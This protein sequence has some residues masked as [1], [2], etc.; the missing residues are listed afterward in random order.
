MSEE[1]GAAGA[2]EIW[3][4]QASTETVLVSMNLVIWDDLQ[5]QH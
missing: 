4:K 2:D 3:A 1:A 5:T